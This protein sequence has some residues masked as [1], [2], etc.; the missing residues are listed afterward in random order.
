MWQMVT[1]A[2]P[3][4]PPQC[5]HVTFRAIGDTDRNMNV[6][7]YGGLLL[8]STHE[9]ELQDVRLR[10][11][12]ALCMGKYLSRPYFPILQLYDI[13]RKSLWEEPNSINAVTCC[14][15]TCWDTIP[16]SHSFNASV[17]SYEGMTR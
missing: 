2:Q 4:V 9:T 5:S 16:Q 3:D 6:W 10:R 17:F 11:A 12:I 1:I 7:T 14:K 15:V 8:Q 13:W